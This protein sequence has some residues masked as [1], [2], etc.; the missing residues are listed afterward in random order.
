MAG[1][2][3][4]F[5]K[6]L[7]GVSFENAIE[8]TTAALGKEGF[9][10]LMT[11]DVKDTLKK[12]LNVDFR[13]YMILGA[14]NPPLA[15]QSLEAEPQLGLLLPCNVVVQEMAPEDV[16]VSFIDPKALFKLVDNPD[17]A[18]VAQEVYDRLRK[19]ADHLG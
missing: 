17:V 12:K 13:R 2:R 4:G 9:G 19:V 8:K 3:Y 14:C 1:F 18:P 7:P 11:I 5:E 15:H 10:V 6:R 16:V